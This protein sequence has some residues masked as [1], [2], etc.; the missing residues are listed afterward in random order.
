LTRMGV[1]L[2][3]VAGSVNGTAGIVVQVPES[4]RGGKG[5]RE[6]LTRLTLT[7]TLSL[8]LRE[9]LT[10]LAHAA[11]GT[12]EGGKVSHTPLSFLRWDG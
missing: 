12:V 9:C 3:K 4:D 10:R 11:G 6:C 8:G 5:L 2:G 7:H 1:D